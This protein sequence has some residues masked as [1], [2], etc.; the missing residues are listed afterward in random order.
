M[1]TILL[2]INFITSIFSLN[3]S[4]SPINSFYN[5]CDIS[6]YNFLTNYNFSDFTNTNFYNDSSSQMKKHKFYLFD[7]E[8]ENL[9]KID[10]DSLIKKFRVEKDIDKF[11]NEDFFKKFNDKIPRYWK[12]IP[13]FDIKDLDD[14]LKE[15]E[16]NIERDSLLKRFKF[17]RKRNLFDNSEI[18][19]I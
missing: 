11:F 5:N 4:F 13:R 2:I 3:S 14:F 15:L 12:D 18:T 6:Q 10:L 17:F 9:R 1:K 7:N 8:I 16:N 19:E